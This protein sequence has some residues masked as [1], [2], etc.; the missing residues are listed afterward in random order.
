MEKVLTGDLRLR[1]NELF[2]LQS[3]ALKNLPSKSELEEKFHNFQ[4]ESL[5]I[6]T[7]FEGKPKFDRTGV[8]TIGIHGH[9]S[10]FNLDDGFPLITTKKVHLKS[11]IHELLWLVR[12]ETNIKYLV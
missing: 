2:D 6:K 5:L 1:Q 7:L 12:G 3:K 11:V 8:A 10:K 4:Y 9:Q